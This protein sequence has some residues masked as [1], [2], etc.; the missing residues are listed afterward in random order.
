MTEG[1]GGGSS[2]AHPQAAQTAFVAPHLPGEE[3]FNALRPGLLTVA[4][5]RLDD[6]RFEFESSFILAAASVEFTRLAELRESWQKNPISIFGHA[7]PI[8][9]DAFN[10][11]LSGRRVRA[12]YAVLVRDPTI[13]ENL[14]K[15]PHGGDKW[16]L[17]TNQI[18]LTALGF[19]AGPIDGI[20][21]KGT[22]DGHKNFSA[23]F[24]GDG[25][26]SVATRQALYNAYFDL[27]CKN[28]EG[29]NFK[30]TKEEFL[31]KGVD[32]D[33]KGGDYQGCGEFNPVLLLPKK[34]KLSKKER[35]AANAPNRRVVAFFFREGLEIKPSDWPCPKWNEG[36][37]KCVERQWTDHA[38]RL[39]P[40]DEDLFREY[41]L[42]RNTM[43]CR[44][45]D[46]LARRSPCEAG[47]KEW[48]LRLFVPKKPP[49]PKE[50]QP[51]DG[52]SD[53]TAPSDEATAENEAESPWKDKA[54][55][56][57]AEFTLTG[58]AQDIK[59]FT[60]ANGFLRARV[61][62]DVAELT[63]TIVGHVI[64]L[65]GGALKEL[66]D[67]DFGDTRAVQER[68]FNLAY[69]PA[70]RELWTANDVKAAITEFRKDFGLP[71]GAV[72]DA[73]KEKL[74]E[75]HGC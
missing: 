23:E 58:A 28:A 66:D 72:D 47:F 32:V 59:G 49:P 63:L 2:G 13:W 29:Q 30:L 20:N 35:D 36:S 10:K 14:H 68:L 38:E 8:G 40:E 64:K 60:D 75:V 46:R 33:G 7:D 3:G 21:G 56:A 73:L 34:P 48:V 4:C 55:L 61:A 43:A 16:G 31:G 19:Y 39:K 24:G 51:G 18:I 17:R 53:G 52:K 50:Q 11:K 70:R 22:Q 15:E 54:P 57:G 9:E 45:Y 44:F 71:D 6:I 5:W 41:K 37:G 26:D 74:R 12:V 27:L 62:A 69:G 42:T 65:K 67:P 25:K 1:S